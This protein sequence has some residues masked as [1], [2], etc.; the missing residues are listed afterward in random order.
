MSIYYKK[1][2]EKM[3]DFRYI[4]KK[5][6]PY[7]FPRFFLMGNDPVSAVRKG[8]CWRENAHCAAMPHRRI[9]ISAESH[10]RLPPPAFCSKKPRPGN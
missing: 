5:N 7:R 1:I 2:N 8:L 10:K 4:R 6:A 3:A 9:G